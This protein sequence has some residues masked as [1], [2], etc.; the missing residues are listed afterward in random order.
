MCIL[1]NKNGNNASK[2]NL[3]CRLGQYDHLSASDFNSLFRMNSLKKITYVFAYVWKRTCVCVQWVRPCTKHVSS[4]PSPLTN[5]FSSSPQAFLP[6]HTCTTFFL[7]LLLSHF[8]WKRIEHYYLNSNRVS[9]K[10]SFD[11]HSAVIINPL[12]CSY[13]AY[14]LCGSCVEPL[15]ASSRRHVASSGFSFRSSNILTAQW[16]V[17]FLP[18]DCS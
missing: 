9:L 4:L 13:W 10:C 8:T 17:S 15:E 11:E 14:L 6:S 5:T 3:K 2:N 1:R 16:W 18:E 12:A 7:P